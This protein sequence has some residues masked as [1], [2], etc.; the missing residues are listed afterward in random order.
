MSF[1]MPSTITVV[2]MTSYNKTWCS[3]QWSSNHNHDDDDDDDYDDDDD[4]VM[5]VQYHHSSRMV[6]SKYTASLT[7]WGRY[8]H[9]CVSNP[10]T[11]GSD[12]GLS[13][14]R[15]QAI[16]WTKLWYC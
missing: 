3:P 5:A 6:S 4:H 11:I 13:P 10:T 2:T 7:N 1:M 9:L 12:N 16:I 14:G 8:T 15:H